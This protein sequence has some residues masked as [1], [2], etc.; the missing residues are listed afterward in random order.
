MD[1][2]KAELTT[3]DL[4][5]S[6][7]DWE[8]RWWIGAAFLVTVITAVVTSILPFTGL[9][10]LVS[11]LDIN[12]LQFLFGLLALVAI[13]ATAWFYENRLGIHLCRRLKNSALHKPREAL[14]VI[15]ATGDSIA[16]LGLPPLLVWHNNWGILVLSVIALSL[17]W[18]ILFS[19]VALFFGSNVLRP[20]IVYV[21][22]IAVG[23]D[24]VAA[25]GIYYS[26]FAFLKCFDV[27]YRYV[28]QEYRM[29][30][31]TIA[32]PT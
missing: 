22:S 28:E 1:A 25:I 18:I 4:K 30:L 15:N 8:P 27:Y 12:P 7:L 24:G 11:R 29:A 14:K 16:P 9:G 23:L 32:P 5:E 2:P 21:S 20:Y 6:D 19:W 31:L 10:N 3:E 26:F 17:S 13:S